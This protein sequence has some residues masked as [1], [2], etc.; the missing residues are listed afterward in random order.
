MINK[1]ESLKSVNKTINSYRE[2]SKYFAIYVND[3]EELSNLELKLDRLY[4]KLKGRYQQLEEIQ[5]IIEEKLE[6]RKYKRDMI[7]FPEKIMIAK[8]F[9]NND[10]NDDIDQQFDY[11]QQEESNRNNVRGVEGL[12]ISMI[13]LSTKKRIINHLN[14]IKDCKFFCL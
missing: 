5:Y 9:N 7:L 8:K 12:K 3:V 6:S 2:G 4:N 10:D 13:K 1:K 11:Q 14:E